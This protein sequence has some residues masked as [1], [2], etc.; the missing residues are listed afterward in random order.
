VWP[1]RGVY[2]R[3]GRLERL[4][5]GF[6]ALAGTT[7]DLVAD[8]HRLAGIAVSRACLVAHGFVDSVV[9]QPAD[10]FWELQYIEAGIFGG[11]SLLC[12]GCTF[13]WVRAR[14]R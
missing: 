11:L 10:R 9:D 4:T 2:R 1:R 12:L 13:W 6:V 8:H 5:G 14:L 7:E 3:C